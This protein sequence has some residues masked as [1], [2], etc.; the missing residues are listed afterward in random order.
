MNKAIISKERKQYLKNKK[1]RK[2]MVLLTQV[3]ILIGFL[4]IWEIL[5]DK[6]IIPHMKL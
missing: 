4:V 3:L 1:I 2:C 6:K 5:A